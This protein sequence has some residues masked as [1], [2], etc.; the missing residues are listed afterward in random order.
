[1]SGTTADKINYLKDTKELLRQELN[2][3]FSDLN[4]TASDPFRQYPS[5]IS[6]S[7]LW[8][9]AWIGGS[10]ELDVAYDGTELPNMFKN[11]Y[12][13]TLSIPNVTRQLEY[14]VA[15]TVIFGGPTSAATKLVGSEFNRI[16]NLYVNNLTKIALSGSIAF[17]VI[18]GIWS[19]HLPSVT[20]IKG[21]KSFMTGETY[22][23]SS[24]TDIYLPKI[25]RIYDYGI[26]RGNIHIGDTYCDLMSETALSN[27]GTIYVPA[28]KLD[29]Y[30]SN[31]TWSRYANKIL[32]EPGT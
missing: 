31:S 2:N 32:A 18:D 23:L 29:W 30:K 24:N 19:L 4:L 15:K 11:R 27:I 10:V 21:I 5:R 25:T 22:A 9:D 16:R 26:R 1:M 6:S 13:N 17:P 7:Q 3:D 14:I 28:S 20:S 12:F 8:M